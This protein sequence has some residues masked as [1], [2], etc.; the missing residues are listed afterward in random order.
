MHLWLG[1]KAGG[2]MGR[3]QVELRLVEGGSGSRSSTVE[4]EDPGAGVDA[5]VEEARR[6][7]AQAWARLYRGHYDEVYRYVLYLQGDAAIAEDL[8]QETFVRA[9]RGIGGYR[10]EASFSTWLHRIAVNVVRRHWRRTARRRTTEGLARAAAQRRAA[11]PE[12]VHTDAT[13]ARALLAALDQ[14][15][16]QLR[17]AFVLRDLLGMPSSE[18]ARLLGISPGNLAVRGHRARAKLRDVLTAGGW[19]NGT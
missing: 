7:D 9:M 13:R 11:S 18:A 6:G 8:A 16:P 3:P 4:H 15:A 14:L 10:R 2:S 1:T 17:E 12:D 5:D 19:A